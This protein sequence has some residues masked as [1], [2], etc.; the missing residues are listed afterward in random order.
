[1]N[2]YIHTHNYTHIHIMK[3]YLTMK[4]EEILIFATI[5]MDLEGIMLNEISQME[6]DMYF[7][8]PFI[9]GI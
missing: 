9:C 2:I 6:K 7:M 3:Y 1:M 8:I 4:N 5:W